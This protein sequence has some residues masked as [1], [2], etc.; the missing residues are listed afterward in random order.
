MNSRVG[1]ITPVSGGSP[2]TSYRSF[3]IG[4]ARL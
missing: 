4:I 3:G 1:G 2:N